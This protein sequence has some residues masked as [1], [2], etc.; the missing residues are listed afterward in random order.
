MSYTRSIQT[1]SRAIGHGKFMNENTNKK[2]IP[3]DRLEIK[4]KSQN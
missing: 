4:N 2:C 3:T 1:K